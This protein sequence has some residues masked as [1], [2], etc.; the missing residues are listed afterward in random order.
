MPRSIP[1][2]YTGPCP[3]PISISGIGTDCATG[4][5]AAVVNQQL[6]AL[7]STLTAYNVSS[8]TASYYCIPTVR[9]LSPCL[10]R[11]RRDRDR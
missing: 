3:G 9:T 6:Q 11:S 10:R 8:L 5:A 7:N 1:C 4:P 2:P